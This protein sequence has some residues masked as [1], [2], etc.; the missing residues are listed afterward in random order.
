MPTLDTNNDW[1]NDSLTKVNEWV[2]SL[3]AFEEQMDAAEEENSEN[4][5]QAK[6]FLS[7]F[8]SKI[9]KGIIA[10]LTLAL[11]MI[12]TVKVVGR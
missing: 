2:S 10:V 11:V 1:M 8:F 5:A 12:V 4:M 9:P 3:E 6:T 7:S